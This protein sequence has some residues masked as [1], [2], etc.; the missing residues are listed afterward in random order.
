MSNEVVDTDAVPPAV[1]PLSLAAG[2]EGICCLI[3]LLVA[4][5]FMKTCS[6]SF[7]RA[8]T[9]PAKDL[10]D[11]VG[12]LSQI[13]GML[14]GFLVLYAARLRPASKAHIKA[15]W[16]V[17]CSIVRSSAPT[18]PS[19]R[20]APLLAFNVFFVAAAIH[21]GGAAALHTRLAQCALITPLLWA[22]L[23]EE[24]LFRGAVFWVTLHRARGDARIA[25]FVAAGAFAAVHVPLALAARAHVGYVA[26]QVVTAG[27]LGGAWSVL[28]A[29][30]GSLFESALLHVANNAAGLAWA[31][32]VGLEEAPDAR[33]PAAC[34]RAVPTTLALQAAGT[35]SLIAQ[36][37]LA[38][39]IGAATWRELQGE[40]GEGGCDAIAAAHP[41]VFGDRDSDILPKGEEN[42]KRG[43]PKIVCFRKSGK[44][45]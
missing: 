10:E 16:S 28:F 30:R 20:A 24:A 45:E 21:R 44:K 15:V 23:I 42:A 17:L 40:G 8:V 26:L 35:A 29:A 11:V 1:I 39:A 4:A 43:S 2:A 3:A 34:D 7:L 12:S 18:V 31:A 38:A 27:A 41:V 37:A 9:L 33:G 13:L 5:G 32:L 6:I 25:V 36:I 19:K 22:P 14:I